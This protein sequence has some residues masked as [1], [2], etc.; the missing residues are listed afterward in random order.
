MLI[1]WMFMLIL[2]A[3]EVPRILEN[4]YYRTLVVYIGLWFTAGF[5]ASMVILRIPIPNP[6]EILMGLGDLFF[7]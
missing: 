1:F 4:Q 3:V 7:E 2:A 5:Y 6:V